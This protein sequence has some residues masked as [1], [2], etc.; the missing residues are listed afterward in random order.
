VRLHPK[1]P[2]YREATARF[3]RL[4]SV[5]R[6]GRAERSTGGLCPQLQ[7]FIRQKVTAADLGLRGL[8]QRPGDVLTLMALDALQPE[9]AL[10][11]TDLLSHE[12]GNW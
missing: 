2:L 1:G 3:P 10:L 6:R 12:S 9:D 5:G 4:R 7:G 8:L 11:S